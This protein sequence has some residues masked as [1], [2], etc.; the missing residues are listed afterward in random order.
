MKRLFLIMFAAV[1]ALLNLSCQEDFNPKTN[2][3]KKYVLNCYINLDYDSYDTTKIYATVSEL[4][5]VDG[6]DPSQKKIK[7]FVSGAKIYFY[8]KSDKYL[9]NE[10]TSNAIS[11]RPPPSS[12]YYYS[13]KLQRIYSNYPVSISAIMPDGT[14]L[15]SQTQLLEA[16][17]LGFSYNFIG[18]F[19][20]R[21]NRFLYGNAFII[22]WGYT[23]GH[24][25]FPKLSI[26]YY[27][28]DG[29][30]T[31]YYEVVPC[32]YVNRNGGYEPVYP[33][34]VSGDSISY[35]YSAIDSTMAK[36]ARSEN[37]NNFDG[38][39]I[40]QMVEMDVPLSKYY[41]SIHGVIDAYSISL[42][43]S[44][45]SNI[46]GGLGIFGSKRTLS[47]VWNLDLSY[48]HSFIQKK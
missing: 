39:I 16:L 5:D 40:F 47:K 19:T 48:I 12:K 46:K 36:I 14:V 38:T 33:S 21:I 44:V 41:E 11:K 2:F 25:L 31:Q 8:Y 23:E 26:P 4:Y 15:S 29:G 24:L 43:Q 6:L 1:P 42:D 13:A 34:P 30:Y 22:F 10:Y 27:K 20:T 7:P 37:F 17:Q 35:D 32:T 3:E 9:L 28:T 45:Y 18:R